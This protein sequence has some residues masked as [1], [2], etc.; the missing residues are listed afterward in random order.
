MKLYNGIT[1]LAETLSVDLKIILS[2]YMLSSHP[3]GLINR[4]P[5]A[6]AQGCVTTCRCCAA[7]PVTA[8]AATVTSAACYVASVSHYR[9]EPA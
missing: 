2:K 4:V 9:V 7:S 1:H 3:Y 8:P 5:A 6:A